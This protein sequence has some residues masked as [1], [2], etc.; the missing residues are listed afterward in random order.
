MKYLYVRLIKGAKAFIDRSEVYKIAFNKRLKWKI[1]FD[2]VWRDVENILRD[3][4]EETQSTRRWMTNY[5]KYS[6]VEQVSIYFGNIKH[7]L[8]T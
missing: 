8:L 7:K 5:I 1:T 6:V 4:K 2:F 3:Y